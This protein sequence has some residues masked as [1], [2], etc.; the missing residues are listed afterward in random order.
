MICRAHQGHRYREPLLYV[1]C[2]TTILDHQWFII[3]LVNLYLVLGGFS[4]SSVIPYC[5]CKK[6][7]DITI[8]AFGTEAPSHPIPSQDQ[9]EQM[10][11]PRRNVKTWRID[12]KNCRNVSGKN[13]AMTYD[14]NGWQSIVRDVSGDHIHYIYCR[15]SKMMLN[16]RRRKR[17][18]SMTS[19]VV[20]RRDCYRG[21]SPRGSSDS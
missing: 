15:T 12:M 1:I 3:T 14:A 9:L 20:S 13:K 8:R 18:Y 6:S 5:A 7:E 4:S 17:K 11:W 10:Q 21:H 19:Y 16:S 2:W